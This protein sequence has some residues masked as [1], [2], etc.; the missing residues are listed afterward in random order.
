K[1]VV[2]TLR[3]FSLAL[4]FLLGTALVPA[5]A[6]E[7][8]N[9]TVNTPFGLKGTSVVLPAGEYAL[10]QI[11]RNDRS[12]FA[13]YLGTDMT[14]SPVAMLRTVPIYYSVGKLPGKTSLILEGS[15]SNRVV[16]E[17]WN[18]QG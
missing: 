15:V 6:Q 7:R 8:I 1:E 11:D 18:V 2:M 12:L 17:G 9:F 3:R 5:F 14:R 13:L 10:F 16:L 4:V